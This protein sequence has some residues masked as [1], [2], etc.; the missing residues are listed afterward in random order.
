MKVEIPIRIT[1]VGPPA[2]VQYA[3]QRGKDELVS[4]TRSEG[5]D[6]VFDLSIT[7]AG[8][9]ESGS[10]RFTGVFTQGPAEERFVYIRIGTMAGDPTSC[11]T[12]RAKVHLSG[13]TSDMVEESRSLPGSIIAGRFPGKDSKGGPFCAS[14]QPNDDGWKVTSD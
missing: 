12:R 5:A 3:L 10:P 9:L 1:L 7:L 11:W 4:V 2:N 14:T 8:K 13:I 6:L